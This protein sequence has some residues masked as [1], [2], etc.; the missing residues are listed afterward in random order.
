[1]T[2]DPRVDAIRGCVAFERGPLVYCFEGADLPTG[3]STED[4]V[5]RPGVTSRPADPV[6]SLASP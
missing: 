2:G 1:M 4:L 5:I 3:A 6:A